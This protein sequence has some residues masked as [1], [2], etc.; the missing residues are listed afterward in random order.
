MRTVTILFFLTC[1]RVFSAEYVIV[2]NYTS[3]T[4]ILCKPAENMFIPQDPKNAEYQKFL[5]W[6]ARQPDA[7]K[8]VF[9]IKPVVREEIVEPLTPAEIKAIRADLAARKITVTK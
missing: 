7:Q 8:V 2:H 5:I 1:L 3:G 6:N 9:T 4:P